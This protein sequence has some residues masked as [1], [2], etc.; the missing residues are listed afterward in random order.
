LY[1]SSFLRRETQYFAEVER[2][3]FLYSRVPLLKVA[4]SLAILLEHFK[5][6]LHLVWHFFA[7][8]ERH[9]LASSDLE[10]PHF[11]TARA[12]HL[13][14]SL[15]AILLF[16]LAKFARKAREMNTRIVKSIALFIL[17]LG[18]LKKNLFSS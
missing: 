7:Y 4:Q 16:A 9:F 5:T 3:H 15:T 13:Q 11:T 10:N 14:V 18:I 2:S 1:N 12:L 17:I 6:K 8:T